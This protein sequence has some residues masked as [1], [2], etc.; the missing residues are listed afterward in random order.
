V[1]EKGVFFILTHIKG[2]VNFVNLVLIGN[3]DI[4][5]DSTNDGGVGEQ[6]KPSFLTYFR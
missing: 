2:V 5:G 6:L 4:A 1:I 3:Y